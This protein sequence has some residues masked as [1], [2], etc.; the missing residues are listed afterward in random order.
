MSKPEI[1]KWL[2]HWAV[3]IDPRTPVKVRRVLV[4][5]MD[6]NCIVGLEELLLNLRRSNLPITQP[7]M[8]RV[9]KHRTVLRKLANPDNTVETKRRL[10]TRKAG[11]EA[12][13]DLLP[14]LLNTV[15]VVAEEEGGIGGG[16]GFGGARPITGE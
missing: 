1:V 7:F 16:G 15:R 14:S 5:T 8:K 12:L 3:L 6:R 4:K 10:I 9:K 2:H 13:A 11:Y